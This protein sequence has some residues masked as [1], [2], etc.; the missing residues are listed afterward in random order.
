MNCNWAWKSCFLII[1]LFLATACGGQRSS[2][3]SAAILR[4]G[5]LGQETPEPPLL[6]DEQS[7]YDP[8]KAINRSGFS[9]FVLDRWG[10]I[11]PG[12]RK[13]YD[14]TI[15]TL[16]NG[17]TFVSVYAVGLADSAGSFFILKYNPDEWRVRETLPGS[18]YGG[19]SK[20]IFISVD[21]FAGSLPFGLA[22]VRPQ[23]NGVVSGD[24]L[25]AEISFMP[26]RATG[27][28]T[29]SATVKESSLI[30]TRYD[31]QPFEGL[32]EV[33]WADQMR[34]DYDN[35]GKVTVADV[36]PL[37]MFFGGIIGDGI[38]NET[39]ELF[40][41]TAG[42]GDDV[43]SIADI[44][45]IAMNYGS[46]ID[47]YNIYR[48]VEGRPDIPEKKLVNLVTSGALLSIDR[49]VAEQFL[50]ANYAYVDATLMDDFTSPSTTFIYRIVPVGDGGE[51]SYSHSKS[52]LVQETAD[53]TPPR[54]PGAPSNPYIGLTAVDAGNSRAKISYRRN[55]VDNVSPADKIKYFLYLGPVGTSY[56]IDLD[57]SAIVEVTNTAPPYIWDGLANGSTYAIYIAAEDEAG[58]RTK[59]VTGAVKTITPS[60]GARNDFTPPVWDTTV[61][62]VTATQGNGGIRV[63][64]GTAHDAQ[65]PPVRFRV[66]YA[67]STEL[68]F[69]T[70]PRLEADS[71]PF[72]ITGL[73]NNTAYTVAVRAIDSADR[74]DP[75]ISPNEDANT[76]TFT[77]TPNAAAGDVTPPV[78]DTTTGVVKAVPG[79]GSI[80]VE[81][82]T[83]TD[84][85]SPPVIYNIYYQQGPQVDFTSATQ[86]IIATSNY[87]PTFIYGLTDGQAYTVIV[88]TADAVGNEEK[89]AVALTTRPDI[90]LD[91]E[92]P[93][94][95]TTIG[96]QYASYGNGLIDVSWN[97]ATDAM[98]PPVG[99]R[100]YWEEGE[101]GITDY[102]AA[103]ASGRTATTTD[104]Y[105]RIEGL[106]NNTAYSVAVR[107][108]DS[109]ATPNEDYNLVFL[110][111]T[112]RGG[113]AYDTIL[114]E[115]HPTSPI[116][117][118]STSVAPN[119]TIGI[120]YT[121][122]N[123]FQPGRFR[124]RLR[125]A[126]SADG[127]RTFT[128][129]LVAG[130]MAN[131]RGKMP[132]LKFDAASVAH[133][134]FI[135]NTREYDTNP[136]VPYT[137]VEYVNRAG[138]TWSAPELIDGGD[139]D[140]VYLNPS[141]AF[142]SAGVP[143]VSYNVWLTADNDKTGRLYYARKDPVWS[144]EEVN[145][146]RAGGGPGQ[147][148]ATTPLSFGV[149]RFGGPPMEVPTIAFSDPSKAGNLFWTLRRGAGDW[150]TLS[151]DDASWMT[152]VGLYMWKADVGGGNFIY[153][154]RISYRFE[155][156][157][158]LYIA[159]SY[160]EDSQLKWSFT[161]ADFS[162]DPGTGFY[163]NVA[164]AF[165]AGYEM[166]F[167]TCW[168][169]NRQK[170]KLCI[171]NLLGGDYMV[172]DVPPYTAV[173]SGEYISM[174]LL[175]VGAND[176]AIVSMVADA[177][178]YVSVMK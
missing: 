81:F 3:S 62:I 98:S 174:G 128:T 157:T 17:D 70:A 173:R 131:S 20:S 45:P 111:E 101:G 149:F 56:G 39:A 59:P 87:P 65:S 38:S 25:I 77:R 26:G 171:E 34:G 170:G 145:G 96:A 123:E 118:T 134:A 23:D 78:W 19:A 55:A 130:D 32:A 164:V 24:G 161:Q 64:F 4:S 108:F 94:W 66:Y 28:R 147:D 126:Q 16:M 177:N 60:D 99:Y 165:Q 146:V 107:A 152:H 95:D 135:N 138:G 142:N 155:T 57:N 83:A 58:N 54:G 9:L 122:A 50:P 110:V 109:W 69:E 74:Y 178:L 5:T 72:S 121:V 61:G 71:S 10:E 49:Y 113:V 105:Y 150:Y 79:E 139:N 40:V 160:V 141:L 73:Q 76:V 102:A 167:A 104:L 153:L 148:G 168:D 116:R 114:V 100:V 172:Y 52:V 42:N 2:V 136:D 151:L 115:D 6:R 119:G 143:A 132:S 140:T 48:S 154:P 85:A 29:T 80:R 120:A 86:A 144:V 163:S 106:T 175:R 67:A 133:I 7:A 46:T 33:A 14:M 162:N 36:T 37:A 89:N 91:N 92:P 51:A 47:G 125:Y 21:K 43:I 159:K 158:A 127:G 75:P 68:L 88:R 176:K 84:A 156:G 22:R 53:T 117:Y 35:T 93:T 12:D 82:G 13:N 31:V 97:S 8:A 30:L 103:I 90:G 41:D 18:F 27:S 166:I 1:V 124:Y 169:M 129:E 15:R 112:P 11:A 63:T 44:T 137:L